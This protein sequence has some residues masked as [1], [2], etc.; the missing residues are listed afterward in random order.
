MDRACS[1]CKDQVNVLF[2]V[3]LHNFY[4]MPVCLKSLCIQNKY[5]APVIDILHEFFCCRIGIGVAD[6]QRRYVLSEHS[7]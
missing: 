3:V 4:C 6:D 2:H 1:Y 5:L 7:L